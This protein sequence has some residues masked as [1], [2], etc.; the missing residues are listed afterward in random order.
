MKAFTLRTIRHVVDK[1][2]GP[3][4]LLKFTTPPKCTNGIGQI[5]EAGI[6]FPPDASLQETATLLHGLADQLKQ[7]PSSSRFS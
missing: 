5:Y 1:E 6:S 2:K 3:T 7:G 4:M